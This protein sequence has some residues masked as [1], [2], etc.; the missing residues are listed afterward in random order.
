MITSGKNTCL[1]LSVIRCY[2]TGNTIEKHL[3]ISVGIFRASEDAIKGTPP[4]TL[5][6]N[7]KFQCVPALLSERS[8]IS[9]RKN[10]APSVCVSIYRKIFAWSV[11]S[12]TREGR[13]TSEWFLT[14]V[15]LE[16]RAKPNRTFGNSVRFGS[17][18]ANRTE[19]NHRNLETR[20]IESNRTECFE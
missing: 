2:V 19:P 16:Q 17:T 13:K 5:V 7:H 12:L 4:L 3:P 8:N 11:E 20:R 14:V 1:I 9:Q 15:S 18:Q 6:K 10:R